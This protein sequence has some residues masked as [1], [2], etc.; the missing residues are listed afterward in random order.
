M[1]DNCI[2]VPERSNWECHLFGSTGEDGISYQPLKGKV[3]NRFV[4]WM[5]K[6]CLAC[7][8]EKVAEK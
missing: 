8:W 3:P 7:K 6:I 5:T 2:K 1:N 4:R